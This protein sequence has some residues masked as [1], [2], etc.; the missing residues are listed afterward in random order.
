MISQKAK[1]ALRALVALAPVVKGATEVR[2]WRLRSKA[3]AELTGNLQPALA[4]TG[5]APPGVLDMD[6]FA[7]APEFLADVAALDLLAEPP[8]LACPA[9]ILQVSHRETP[10]PESTR[11]VQVLGAQARLECIR[12][13]PFWDRVDDVETGALAERVLAFLAAALEG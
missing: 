3:R 9:L 6:G 1:Y 2:L 12:L 7:V 5:A 8:R 10:S 13:A 4:V 11:L